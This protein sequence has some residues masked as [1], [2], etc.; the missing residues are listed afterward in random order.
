MT[1]HLCVSGK[2]CKAS[3]TND[4][5]QRQPRETERPDDLCDACLKHT[6]QRVEQ[7]PEQWIRLH[8][9]IGE[10][11]AGVDVNIRRPKPSG[12]VPLNLHVDTLLGNIVTELT[13][14][15]EVVADKTNMN[16]PAH[17]DPARQVQ[18][19]VRIVAPH[20][21]TLI[22]ATGV[23]GRD[24]DDKAI[25]VM[26]W[27]P[28][29]L[30]HMPS[31]TTGVQIVKQLGHLAALAFYTL[32]LTLARDKRPLPCNRCHSYS[33]GRWAGSDWWDCSECGAQFAEDDI[34]RQDKILLALHKRG[35]ITPATD[36]H[37]KTDA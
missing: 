37:T 17:T 12:T 21:S 27:A 28:N 36:T 8:N 14:A 9:M 32:G 24:P 25:D 15:A 34:R 11:H 23:G 29:G 33:V 4:E 5:G 2:S 19:C 35:I 13:T 18:A 7:L 22:H 3:F 20:L 1:E 30:I 10:R 31:T 26:T 16:N 6:T